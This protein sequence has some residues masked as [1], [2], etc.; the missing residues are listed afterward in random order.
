M[1]LRKINAQGGVTGKILNGYNYGI[2]SFGK[3]AQ[4]KA[5]SE[6]SVRQKRPARCPGF[7]ERGL[8][9]AG[10]ILRGRLISKTEKCRRHLRPEKAGQNRGT[11]GAFAILEE[12]SFLW[13]GTA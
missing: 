10:G 8:T 13:I 6:K 4:G 9:A 12:R 5:L 2:L 11:F 3:G 7:D 1:I